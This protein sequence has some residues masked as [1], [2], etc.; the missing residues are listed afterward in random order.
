M[1]HAEVYTTITEFT[2]EVGWHRMKKTTFLRLSILSLLSVFGRF[3]I[4]H[5]LRVFQKDI[6]LLNYDNS[7]GYQEKAHVNSQKP[8]FTFILGE[9]GFP[10]AAP[11]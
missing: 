8:H 9:V 4:W 3:D 11:K 10:S 5:S 2:V 6:S 7:L 1:V